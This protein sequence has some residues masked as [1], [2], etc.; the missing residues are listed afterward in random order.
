MTL[1]SDSGN[2]IESEDS[3]TNPVSPCAPGHNRNASLSDSKSV[4]QEI[5]RQSKGPLCWTVSDQAES[6]SVNKGCVRLKPGKGILARHS[7]SRP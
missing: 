4:I 1:T 7:E 2:G 3:E 5:L 6:D